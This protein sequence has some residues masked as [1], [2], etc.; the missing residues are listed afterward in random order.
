MTAADGVSL[1]G[2]VLEVIAV[3]LQLV[4]F[5]DTGLTLLA[6]VAALSVALVAAGL[7]GIVRHRWV[8]ARAVADL[9]RG[10]E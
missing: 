7:V 8:A 6:F 2:I 9:E 4:G 10:A 3:T 5:L 1:D